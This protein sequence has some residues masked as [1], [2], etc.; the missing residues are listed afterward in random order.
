MKV[1]ERWMKIA[2]ALLD[3]NRKND[4]NMFLTRRYLRSQKKCPV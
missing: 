4:D 1:Y 2:R 3:K